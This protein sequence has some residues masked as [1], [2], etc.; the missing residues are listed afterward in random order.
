MST[1]GELG[2]PIVYPASLGQPIPP[3]AKCSGK[4]YYIK[5]VNDFCFFQKTVLKTFIALLGHWY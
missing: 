1:N 5:I 2:Y 4:R 3:I